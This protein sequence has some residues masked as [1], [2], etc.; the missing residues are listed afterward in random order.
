MKGILQYRSQKAHIRIRTSQYPQAHTGYR[1]VPSLIPDR[2]LIYPLSRAFVL[3]ALAA[4]SDDEG[5]MLGSVWRVEIGGWTCRRPRLACLGI[6]VG[7]GMVMGILLNGGQPYQLERW[8]VGT[9]CWPYQRQR[10]EGLG[11]RSVTRM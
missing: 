6:V 11:L 5:R 3:N 1:D 8:D 9:L 2:Q 7:M 10:A 4:G